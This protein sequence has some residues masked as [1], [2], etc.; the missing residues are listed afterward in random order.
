MKTVRTWIELDRKAIAANA[1]VFRRLIGPDRIL[2]A[3]VKSNAYGHGLAHIAGALAGIPAFA[4]R[5]WFGVDSI[6]EALRLRREGITQPI[7]VL[8]F[9]LPERLADAAAGGITVTISNFEALGALARARK[10]P[11]FHLKI[12]TGMHRQ[13]F[14]LADVPRLIRELK[15]RGLA[16]TGVYTHFAAAKDPAY[17]TF[18]KLQLAEFRRAVLLLSRAGFRQLVR[19]AAASGGTI[20]FPDARLDMA[21]IGMGLYGYWPSPEARVANRTPW[22]RLRQVLRWKTVVAEIKTIP[23]G[24]FVGYD[25][26]ERVAHK[27]AIAVLPIGYWHGYDRGLSGIGEALIRGKRVRV[28]GRVSMDMI[29]VDVTGVRGV[30]V[31]DE[32]VLIG[33]SGREELWADDTALR[34]GTSPYEFLTRLNPLIAKKFI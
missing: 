22:L 12:D 9:T 19:H 8:G 16:P 14:L 6:T 26:T 13:G 5:G 28:L 30:R 33:R 3:V 7:L 32:A 15:R 2:M 34:I 25:L 27:A 17:P 11:A 21:R 4:R 29:V 18:T 31:G 1:A 20:L 10:R 23:A 24:S